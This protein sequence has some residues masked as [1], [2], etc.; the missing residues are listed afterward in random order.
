[1]MNRLILSLSLFLLAPPTAWAQQRPEDRVDPEWL[2]PQLAK[3]I[4]YSVPGIERIKARKDVVWKR[5]DGV[6]LKLDLYTPPGKPRNRPLP[7][8]VFI[9]GGPIP[10]NLRT[11]PKDWGVYISYGQLAAASGFVGI[12][13]NH[14]FYG[15][16]RLRDAQSDVNDLVGYLRANAAALG[17]D[18]D[19]ITLWA[20]SGGGPM[21]S[22][23]IRDAAPYIRCLIAYYAL[24]DTAGS[25]ANGEGAQKEFSPL[26]QLK[27]KGQ[28]VP[29]L[30]VARAGLDNPGLNSA[31]DRF[32][33]EAITRN[34]TF[35]FSNHAAGRHSFDVL[36]DDERT[37]EIIRRTIEFIKARN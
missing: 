5:V 4:V 28:S 29:P 21:L 10:S 36:N 34:V 30:F 15:M 35:E 16:D 24:L 12:T 26:Y 1:M 27:Q 18:P 31:L 8:V 7:V 33:Q 19:R 11:E 25:G 20:F 23:A 2:K 6:E 3:R 32:A 37:R 14:R 22:S 17:I 9:H 13:F